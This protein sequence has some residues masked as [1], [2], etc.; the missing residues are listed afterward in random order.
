MRERDCRTGLDSRCR[1]HDG[2]IRQ[3]RGDTLIGTLR[4][5]YGADFAKGRRR[6]MRLDTFLDE[7]RST[8]LTSYLKNE[9]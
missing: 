5:T 7:T 9:P 2:T 1:D 6:D 4:R 3:K 8:S